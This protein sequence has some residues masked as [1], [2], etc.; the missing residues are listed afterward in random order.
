VTIRAT[1]KS[2]R[3]LVEDINKAM[4]AVR[5][6]AMGNIPLPWD[7]LNELRDLVAQLAKKA[8]RVAVDDLPGLAPA[9]YVAAMKPVV[10]EYHRQLMDR[11]LLAP[12][13]CMDLRAHACVVLLVGD[14]GSVIR[15][16]H[17]PDKPEV[18]LLV[19]TVVGILDSGLR[20]VAA[21]AAAV[22][23]AADTS[24]GDVRLCGGCDCVEGECGCE[25]CEGRSP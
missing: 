20:Q 21:G 15:T 7:D 17:D 3:L 19:E 6:A 14:G 5:K 13:L 12:C 25:G 1:Y 10:A 22:A 23:D 9:D 24:P 16:A 8:D 4:E 11:D 18:A 2:V